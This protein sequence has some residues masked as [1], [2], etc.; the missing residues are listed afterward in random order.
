MFTHT[1]HYLFSS[2]KSIL[3]HVTYCL[4]DEHSFNTNDY[5]AICLT[6]HSLTM[7]LPGI[8]EFLFGPDIVL[9][10]SYGLLLKME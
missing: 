1:H 5:K 10:N 2:K 7:L 8:L 9:A 4:S 6:Q 3:V